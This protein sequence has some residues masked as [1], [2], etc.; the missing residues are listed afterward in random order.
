[1]WNRMK[2][3]H[4]EAGVYKIG[5][6]ISGVGRQNQNW[7][8]FNKLKTFTFLYIKYIMNVIALIEMKNLTNSI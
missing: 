3:S 2:L 1:M 6:C 7:P 4:S 8:V 5:E